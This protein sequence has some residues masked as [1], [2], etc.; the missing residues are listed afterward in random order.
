MSSSPSARPLYARADVDGLAKQFPEMQQGLDAFRAGLTG[1]DGVS[2]PRRRRWS[3]RPPRSSTATGSPSTSRPI[4]T[5]WRRWA[6]ARTATP[7][8]GLS[9]KTAAKARALLGSALKDAVTSVER[10]DVDETLGD[11]LVAGVDLR[12]TYAKLRSGLPELFTGEMAQSAEDELPSVDDVPDKRID[13]SF[14]VRDGDLTRVELDVAQFLDEPAGHLVLRA[15]VLPA[16]KITAPS[17]A[18]EFDLATLLQA[19]MAASGSVGGATEGDPA[20]DLDAYTVATW[21]DQDIAS[22]ASEDGAAPSVDY[23]QT[24][25]PITK[26]P[27]PAWSSPPSA[28]RSRWR[29]TETWSA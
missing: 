25:L 7:G 17:D 14:W 12:K 3:S 26:A 24:V 11:H 15:D 20:M 27:H 21:L 4:W 2:E 5:S 8:H 6:T 9:K 13:V 18:V 28:S 29:S 22:T 10:R 23:L 1:A 16:E 19:G